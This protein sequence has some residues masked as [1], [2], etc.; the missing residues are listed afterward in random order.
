MK[1]S[2]RDRCSS[3]RS[4]CGPASG[5]AARVFVQRAH[6]VQIKNTCSQ[7]RANRQGHGSPAPLGAGARSSYPYLAASACA[8]GPAFPA[9][10]FVPRCARRSSRPRPA[11]RGGHV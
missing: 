3:G 1:S 4:G 9:L 2:R 8:V 11:T 10:Q 5:A 7:P 6:R